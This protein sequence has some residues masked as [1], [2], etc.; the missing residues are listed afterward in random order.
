MTALD[1]PFE[2]MVH[3]E[4]NRSK[5]QVYEI[6]GNNRRDTHGEWQTAGMVGSGDKGDYSELRYS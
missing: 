2:G 5:S 3:G 1:R 4:N 6:V